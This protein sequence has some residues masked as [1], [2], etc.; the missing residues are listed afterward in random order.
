VLILPVNQNIVG[1]DFLPRGSGIV[2][3]RPLASAPAM[4][5]RESLTRHIGP[6]ID[7]QTC[8]HSSRWCVDI[9]IDLVSTADLLLANGV[10][11]PGDAALGATNDSEWGEFL[12]LP[13]EKFYD[14]N[15]IRGTNVS[16]RGVIG[17][18]RY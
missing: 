15:K 8:H 10:P 12:H 11:K 13:G 14:F 18:L 7:Q 6:S 17:S 5:T 9:I 3:R 16:I 1:R 4:I 2:T